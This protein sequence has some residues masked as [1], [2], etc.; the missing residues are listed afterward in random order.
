[1]MD[2][3]HLFDLF[4]SKH[5]VLVYPRLWEDPYENVLATAFGISKEN[6]NVRYSYESH[7]KDIYGICWSTV[8]ENDAIWKIY[9]PNKNK[10][11]LKTTIGKPS[12]TVSS[13]E[14][15]F[16]QSR[17]GKVR[18]LGER[19]IKGNIAKIF[20]NFSDSK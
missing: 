20:K 3:A 19:I 1:M 6:E 17:I 7:V 12:N 10:V 14:L 2:P 9:S 11:K 13:I 4:R 18:Y 5:L 15:D 16:L 8:T